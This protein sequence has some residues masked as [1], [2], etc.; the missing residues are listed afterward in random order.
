MGVEKAERDAEAGMANS[1]KIKTRGSA[2]LENSKQSAKCA[3]NPRRTGS[4][5]GVSVT[6]AKDHCAM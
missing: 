1:R 5:H 3:V 2:Q 6:A 4:S